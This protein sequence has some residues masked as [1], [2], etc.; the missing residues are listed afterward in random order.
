MGRTKP[1]T[2]RISDSGRSMKNRSRSRFSPKMSLGDCYGHTH[3]VSFRKRVEPFRNLA[4]VE[5]KDVSNVFLMHL[6]DHLFPSEARYD[7]L[8]DLLAYIPEIDSFIVRNMDADKLEI[9]SWECI[10]ANEDD[11]EYEFFPIEHLETGNFKLDKGSAAY[12]TFGCTGSNV[13]VEDG[14]CLNGQQTLC[15]ILHRVEIDDHNYYVVHLTGVEMDDED[16]EWWACYD[17]VKEEDL[18]PVSEEVLYYLLE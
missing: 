4:G 6:P 16:Y 3:R 11:P 13:I 10:D 8:C 2:K 18:C 5:K 9:L 12:Y 15:K 14:E 17:L 7:V 1:E